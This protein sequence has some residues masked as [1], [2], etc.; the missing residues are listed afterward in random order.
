MDTKTPG[1]STLNE[2]E[3]RLGFLQHQI[4]LKLY[5][6]LN[7]DDDKE[8]YLSNSFWKKMSTIFNSEPLEA[9][10]MFLESYMRQSG[11]MAIDKNSFIVNLV[12]ASNQK[13]YCLEKLITRY[14]HPT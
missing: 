1:K 6:L 8:I 10:S 3:T 4:A 7:F 9:L 5:N 13:K 12:E 11:R 14:T 2:F